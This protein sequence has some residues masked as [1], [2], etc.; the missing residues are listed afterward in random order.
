MFPLP[1]L[2]G[3]FC[4]YSFEDDVN[5]MNCSH[6]NM[7]LLPKMV[8]PQTQKLIMTGN[9][10]VKMETWNRNLADITIFDLQNCKIIHISNSVLQNILNHTE[11]LLLSQNQIRKLPHL[12]EKQRY[13][14]KLWLGDNPY[15]CNCGMMWMRDW[16]QNTTNVMDKDNITCGLGKWKGKVYKACANHPSTFFHPVN[17]L[18][19]RHSNHKVEQQVFGMFGFSFLDWNID[20]MCSCISCCCTDFNQ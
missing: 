13:A 6:K 3:C 1:C 12:F 11:R 17:Y 10:L 16:L 9:H 18:F 15:H 4:H 2:N 5:T 8:L 19:C 7:T 14:T 20:W